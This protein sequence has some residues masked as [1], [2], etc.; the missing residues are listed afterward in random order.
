MAVT[1]ASETGSDIWIID[2][3]RGTR[4]RFTA[5]GISA[6]PVW[7][8]DGSKVA[9]QSTAPGPWNL[10][11]KPLDASTDA[12]PLLSVADSSLA[13]SWP[14]TGVS[15]LP[16]TPPTLSGAGPQF[17]TSWSPDG[18]TLAFHERKPNGERDIWVVSP[19]SDPVPFLLTSFDARSP[20][21]SPDGKWIAYVSDESGRNDV[22][23]QPFPGPGPK[24]LISTD[25]G[26]DPV[27]SKDGRELFF[28]RDDQLMVVSVAPKGEFS[29][30]RPRRLFEIRFDTGENGPNYD[31][32]RDGR[33]FVMP[34]S[35]RGPAP[36]ELHVVLNWFG[37]VAT[38]TQAAT[39]VSLNGAH[40]LAALQEA[41][42][43]R[44]RDLVPRWPVLLAAGLPQAP[45]APEE[46]VVRDTLQRYSTAL[47]SLD[48][49][50][51]KKVQP[52]IPTETL[53][54]AFKDM[55]ELK[56]AIDQVRVLSSDASTA[57]VS[58][59]VTQT[60]TPKVGS[61]R[62]TAVTRVMRL[63]RNA[64]AW[65]IDGFER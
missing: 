35:D 42:T 11:W 22:Y 64:D 10:F 2:L 43:S 12:Q 29:A 5:G 56:V 50:A 63:R 36:R 31:V 23:V 14:N 58:C 15:L 21:F 20:R 3:E 24:W 7:G 59:R 48:A 44:G 61:K 55:R 62:I 32:S 19:G 53:A 65:V 16:G 17:P 28:R 9:F 45:A 6:F 13:Q 38:R 34:R 54:K 40:P 30:D 51:V 1:I 27:W 26:I 57:R 8:P 60:L 52:S 33:W 46:T 4:T 39:A 49:N 25:G 41:A 37:E 47:E 18:S